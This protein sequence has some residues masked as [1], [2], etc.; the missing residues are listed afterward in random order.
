MNSLYPAENLSLRPVLSKDIWR[1][2]YSLLPTSR[3]AYTCW[4]QCVV[5]VLLSCC[6]DWRSHAAVTRPHLARD[7]RWDDDD[8][9]RRRYDRRQLT[10]WLMCV[11]H[12]SDRWSCVR[13]CR[14]S[15]V[16][17]SAYRRRHRIV[18]CH[19]QT[20]L[21]DLFVHTIVRRLTN[22]YICCHLSLKLRFTAG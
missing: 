9:S 11:A 19:I 2:V 14:T 5:I 17:Q 8:I 13:C 21:E 18:R 20:A 7:L 10:S 4:L 16:E 3:S 1:L 15:S 6:H 22:C 12:D